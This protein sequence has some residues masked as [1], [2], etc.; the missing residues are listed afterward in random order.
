MKLSRKLG[1]GLIL[2]ATTAFCGPITYTFTG[3]ANGT[4]G[5]DQIVDA[6]FTVTV[7]A[8]TASI[9]SFGSGVRN[10]G[11]ITTIDISGFPLATFTD[12]MDVADNQSSEEI[13]FGDDTTDSALL[14]RVDPAFAGYDLAASYGP[15]S[16][17]G[18]DTV[19]ASQFQNIPTDQGLLTLTA[20][21]ETFTALSAPEP[22]STL[23]LLSGAGLLCFCI[24]AGG[25]RRRR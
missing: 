1:A 13:V 25:L 3:T 21:E 4:L 2:I 20:S 12:V 9:V 16:L 15:I 23:L 6:A 5:L 11:T 8:D 14:L 24:G 18:E 17:H 10:V 7:L 22:A 19:S